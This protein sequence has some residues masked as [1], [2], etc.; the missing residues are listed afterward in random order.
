MQLEPVVKNCS[1]CNTRHTAPF[2]R[3][4]KVVQ[5]EHCVHC[6]IPHEPPVGEGCRRHRRTELFISQP[7]T[8]V[9]Q[10]MAM[11]RDTPISDKFKDRSDP[12]YLSFL[13]EQL[14]TSWRTK[15]ESTNFALI[16]SRLEALELAQHGRPGASHS[17]PTGAGGGMAAGAVGGTPAGAVGGVPVGSLSGST[18]GHGSADRR[19]L[20]LGA[21]DGVG[22]QAAPDPVDPSLLPLTDALAQLTLAVDPAAGKAKGLFLRPEYYYQHVRSNTPLKQL[23]HT[24]LSYK[25]MVYGWFCVMEH[26]LSKG[27][28]LSGYIG[29]CKFVAEQAYEHIYIY[30]YIY[31]F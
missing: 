25:E 8:T 2:G 15:S 31:I 26:L 20:G 21:G 10:G 5:F 27:G 30:I 11:A 19:G 1:A 28:D 23:D 3:Y 22:H 4:C 24:K 6:E 7:S 17:I 9:Q 13:E 16:V 18:S 29:H 12:D 14:E